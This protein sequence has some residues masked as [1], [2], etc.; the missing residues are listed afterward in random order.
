M[1]LFDEEILEKICFYR[2]Q[3][4]ALKKKYGLSTRAINALFRGEMYTADDVKENR[5]RLFLIRNIGRKTYEE[6]RRKIGN[7]GDDWLT[8]EECWQQ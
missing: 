5:N 7:D 4:E 3:K 8:W 2:E 6:I 1:S